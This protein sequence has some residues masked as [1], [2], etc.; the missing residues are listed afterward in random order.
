MASANGMTA[1]HAID[2]GEVGVIYLLHFDQPFK[3]TRHY[4]GWASNL[5]ARLEHHRRGTG[6]RLLAVLNQHGIGWTLARTWSG[7]RSRERQLKNMGGASRRCPMC[8]I[9]V[10]PEGP[11]T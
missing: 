3:H 1:P 11:V 9:K 5:E 6:A 2:T 10:K 7:T 8:G 4:I